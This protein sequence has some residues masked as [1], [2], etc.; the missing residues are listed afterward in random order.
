MA[1]FSPQGKYIV[2]VSKK[3]PTGNSISAMSLADQKIQTVVAAPTNQTIMTYPRVSPN[4]KW[5]AYSSNET[6]RALLYV[7]SFPSGA[8][9]WQVSSNSGDMPVWRGDGKELYYLG[10]SS[11]DFYAVSI[12]ETGSQFNLG[13]PKLLFRQ[14]NIIATGRVYDANPDG[15]RFIARW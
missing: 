6:G 8:G 10:V 15:S 9:K 14:D 12:S 7:T 3:G 2:F 4:G 11:S 5:L 13:Q 1:S